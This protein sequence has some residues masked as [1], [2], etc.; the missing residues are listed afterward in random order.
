MPQLSAKKRDA[1][2]P[3][4]VVRGLRSLIGCSFLRAYWLFLGINISFINVGLRL[5]C[6]LNISVIRSC[7]FLT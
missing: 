2:S 3:K 4:V 7:I 5:C 1:F 6:V